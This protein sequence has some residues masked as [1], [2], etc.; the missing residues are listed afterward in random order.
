[1]GIARRKFI[2]GMSQC[3]W[4]TSTYCYKQRVTLEMGKSLTPEF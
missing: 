1:M 2:A 4:L 3:K